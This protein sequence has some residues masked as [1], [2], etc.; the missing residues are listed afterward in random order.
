MKY[1]KGDIL[2][3]KMSYV[4]KVMDVNNITK[5]VHVIEL[6]QENSVLIPRSEYYLDYFYTKVNYKKTPLW[7]KLEGEDD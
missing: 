6:D 2:E 5:I 3:H 1:N 7:K 4:C